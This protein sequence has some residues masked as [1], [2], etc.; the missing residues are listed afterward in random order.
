[1]LSGHRISQQTHEQN[2]C[3]FLSKLPLDI[4]LIIFEMLLGGSLFHLSA[5]NPKSRI[6]LHVCQ[7]RDPID[8][9]AHDCHLITLRR[10]NE[11]PS[12]KMALLP[13]LMTCRQIYSE[14]IQTLYQANVFEV[15]Q[16]FVAFQFLTMMVPPQRLQAIRKFRWHMRIPHHPQANA[17]SQRDWNGLFEFFTNEMPSLQDLFLHLQTMQPMETEIRNTPDIDGTDW[18][19]PIVLMTMKTNR[20]RSCKVEVAMAQIKHDVVAVIRESSQQNPQ[21][22]STQVMYKTCVKLHEKFRSSLQAYR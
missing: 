14:A 2:Q 5:Q 22:D 11:D 10:P 3:S 8:D 21:A 6:V 16:N 7:H 12:K 1:M 18:I 15:R 17:R 19:R 4:R 13:I 9:R 20:E